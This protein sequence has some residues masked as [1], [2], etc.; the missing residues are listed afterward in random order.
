MMILRSPVHVSCTCA[1]NSFTL[2][3]PVILFATEELTRY[4]ECM[5]QGEGTLQ[6][7][8]V[9]LTDRLEEPLRYD[10]Y[11][12]TVAGNQ[13]TIASQHERGILYG[14]YEFLRVLG[15][16]FMFPSDQLETVPQLAH[17]ELPDQTIRKE[18]WIEFRGLCLYG[19]TQETIQQTAEMVDWMAKNNYNLL[20]TSVHRSDD[21][22]EGAH[23]ILWD[24]T[25]SDLLPEINKRGIVIDMSEHSTD[26]FFP[27]EY[28]FNLHPEWFSLINGERS[29]YQLCYSNQDVV[30]EYARSYLE[31]ARSNREFQILGIWPLDGGGYCECDKCK[32]PLTL[33]RANEYI[34]GEI[35]KVR[36]D[37]II[38][39][40][41]YTPQSFARPASS[42][43]QNMS[44]LVCNVNNIV[45]YEWGLKA[46]NSGGAFYFDY[47]TGDHYR[48]RSN[49]WIHP[50]YIREMVNTFAAYNYRGII[51]LYL[52]ITSWWQ[53]S[54]N[55]YYLSRL[56]YDPTASVEELTR[57][58]CGDLYGAENSERMSEILMKV[59]RELQDQ[60]LWSGMPH[61]HS[62]YSE[63]ITDRNTAVDAIHHAK[64]KSSLQTISEL[65]HEAEPHITQAFAKEQL[66]YL[67]K[68]IELQW[69]Y[70]TCVDQYNADIDTPE[71]AEA[72]FL[73]L[74]ELEKEYGQ[75]FISENYARWRITGRDN[76]FNPSNTNEYQPDHPPV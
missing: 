64:L 57:A 11:T 30:R 9:S 55:Y 71:R 48:F 49:L 44:V 53:A 25:A 13:V 16:R 40:L 46:K 68:Y 26:Y 21:A 66:A 39:H 34:A 50:F 1:S 27:R 63:H 43:P 52:P 31:F 12:V 47:H 58:L 3:S 36:P 5:F 33:L 45:A 75:T 54:L 24:E 17:L 61:K 41:A 8:Q 29:Q 23:A 20:L 10:G 6:Q 19:T 7:L 65:L 38:E 22:V 70:F 60:T 37:L 74:R 62:Y 69:L 32:D 18:P 14:V 67:K 73:A 72:Y 76:I 59:F 56:Y 51:S 35:A 4:I 42:L 28:W 15:C 2:E